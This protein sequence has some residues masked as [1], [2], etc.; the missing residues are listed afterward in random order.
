MTVATPEAVIGLEL[1]IRKLMTS[2]SEQLR[3][4]LGKVIKDAPGI[5]EDDAADILDYSL[6]MISSGK[7]MSYM[8]AELEGICEEGTAKQIGNMVTSFLASNDAPAKDEKIEETKNSDSGNGDRSGNGNGKPSDSASKMI[9]IKS[10]KS[11]A[12]TVSG[13]LGSSRPEKKIMNGALESSRETKKKKNQKEPRQ[14]Q[15]NGSVLQEKNNK[16]QDTRAHSQTQNRNSTMSNR[17]KQGFNGGRNMGGRGNSRKNNNSTFNNKSSRSLASDALQRLVKQDE[18]DRG[19]SR[20]ERNHQDRMGRGGRGSGRGRG[21]QQRDR[22]HGQVGNGQSNSGQKRSSP[23]VTVSQGEHRRNRNF[24]DRGNGKDQGKTDS[25]RDR[26][27]R[28]VERGFGGGGRGIPPPEKASKRARLETNNRGVRRDPAIEHNEGQQLDDREKEA[29]LE[30]GTKT[31]DQN[32]KT[33]LNGAKSNSHDPSFGY[34]H[35]NWRGRFNNRGGRFDG[36]GRGRGFGERDRRSNVGGR[37]ISNTLGKDE[38][39][40][41]LENKST[42]AAVLAAAEVSPSPLV[43]ASFGDRFSGRGFSFRGRSSWG[44]GRGR[45]GYSGRADVAAML[46]SKSWSRSKATEK[47]SNESLH[48]TAAAPSSDAASNSAPSSVGK[49]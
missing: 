13:A 32:E 25:F 42:D 5:S 44:R 48:N 6:A 10:L 16:H 37:G 40:N 20:E 18:T 41:P 39:V 43:A 9:P 46:A 21:Q 26:G 27:V 24:V 22:P 36:R 15:N 11:N 33:H 17:N 19:H 29:S 4:I 45:G 2:E 31:H 23:N 38:K 49:I 7:T 3:E 1:P 8:V 35:N 28:G 30:K 34:S 47:P 14:K 12:L